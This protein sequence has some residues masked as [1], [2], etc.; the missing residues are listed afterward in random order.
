MIP[1]PQ[2]HPASVE[3]S[4][5]HLFPLTLWNYLKKVT[6]FGSY[7]LNVQNFPAQTLH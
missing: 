6:S 1:E 7:I 5:Q 3:K 4:F 2:C